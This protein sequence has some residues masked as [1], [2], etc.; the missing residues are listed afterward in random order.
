[1]RF[2]SVS[3]R[4]IFFVL[5]KVFPLH[6]V[7][8]SAQSPISSATGFVNQRD[9]IPVQDGADS[10]RI[11]SFSPFPCTSAAQ[12]GFADI[13]AAEDEPAASSAREVFGSP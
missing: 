3:D 2:Y 13:T 12:L 11:P 5:K 6:Q 4:Q 9:P 7:S 10:V 8:I 1:M